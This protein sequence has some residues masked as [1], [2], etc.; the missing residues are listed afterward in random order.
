MNNPESQ[1]SHESSDSPN[2][3]SSLAEEP[4]FEE[5]MD[6]ME[7]SANWNG[8]SETIKQL[9]DAL[10]ETPVDTNEHQAD[11]LDKTMEIYYRE[12]YQENDEK[13][14]KSQNWPDSQK[15]LLGHKMI[16]DIRKEMDEGKH[17]GETLYHILLDKQ[18]KVEEEQTNLHSTGDDGVWTEQDNIEHQ[19]L[20]EQ[21]EMLVMMSDSL[22]QRI[23]EKG[24]LPENYAESYCLR[25]RNIETN[26]LKNII[27]N[28]KAL[29]KE[30]TDNSKLSDVQK[31]YQI[32]Q[33]KDVIENAYYN[34]EDITAQQDMLT[35]ALLEKK[36]DETTSEV[37]QNKL[38][39]A[40]QLTEHFKA[41]IDNSE[42]ET[43]KARLRKQ[44]QESRKKQ[45]RLEMVIKDLD[46]PKML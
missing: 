45:R 28:R 30:V 33:S 14:D 17:V 15:A 46:E 32:T 35:D 12:S 8:N 34:L 10:Y 44:F 25:K 29:I 22:K 41:M 7:E 9:Y 13:F 27:K 1:K 43:V 4:S 26:R 31:N 39:K 38:V 6:N 21:R 24:E 3:W 11:F 23:I 5:H 19:T 16:T 42:N 36:G 18:A 40:T 37:L 20:F 2:Q